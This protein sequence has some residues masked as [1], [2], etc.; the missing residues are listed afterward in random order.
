[1]ITSEIDHSRCSV[2]GSHFTL[3][4]WFRLISEK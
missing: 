4:V 3:V 1:M 2:I